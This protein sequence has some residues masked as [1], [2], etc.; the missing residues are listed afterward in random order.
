M[1]TYT[2]I[3]PEIDKLDIHSRQL[4]IELQ[5][6]L[7]KT[8]TTSKCNNGFD[9][10]SLEDAAIV[11]IKKGLFKFYSDDKF[12]RMYNDNDLLILSQ[13]SYP[14]T[15]ISEFSSEI[16]K[17][18]QKQYITALSAPDVAL[19]IISIAGMQLQIMHLLCASYSQDEIPFDFSFKKYDSGTAI[20]TE[21]DPAQDIY[22]LISGTAVVS[23]QGSE[24]GTVMPGEVFGEISFFT[25]GIRSATVIAKTECMVQVMNKDDFLSL[26]KIKPSVNMAVSKL[27]AE[28]LVQ[29]NKKIADSE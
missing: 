6:H 7:P 10:F 18:T 8:D 9:L 26:V 22:T 3:S 19:Q 4:C 2:E 20:I 13:F 11:I 21:G 25:D 15:C 1:I 28:R 5:K 29:T 14:A 16:I 23:V 17:L 27:L 24:V 12:I